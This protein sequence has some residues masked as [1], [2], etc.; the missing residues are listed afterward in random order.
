M[1]VFRVAGL[2]GYKPLEISAVSVSEI[3]S[4]LRHLRKAGCRD[5]VLVLHSF[6]LLK[7]GGVRYEHTRPDRLVIRRLKKLCCELARL[8]GEVEVCVLGEAALSRPVAP[9]QPQIVPSL[10]WLQPSMRKVV[11][12][13]NRLPWF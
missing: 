2:P 10:P 8:R 6:S 12:A 7:N 9:S 13:V 3:L 4:T 11:Q 1:T 5:A